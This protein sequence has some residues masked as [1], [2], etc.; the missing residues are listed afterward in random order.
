MRDLDRIAK[1]LRLRK[2]HA[3]VVHRSGRVALTH[4]V[5][6]SARDECRELGATLAAGLAAGLW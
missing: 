6:E 4:P 2:V 3:G 5:A 1:G